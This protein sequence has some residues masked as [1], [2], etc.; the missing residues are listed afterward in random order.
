MADKKALYFDAG[1]SEV[2][3]C[4]LD[5]SRE[6]FAAS[7]RTH[8]PGRPELC[9]LGALPCV[10]SVA[11]GRL[12]ELA[13]F[14]GWIGG[15]GVDCSLHFTGFDVEFGVERDHFIADQSK[16]LAALFGSRTGV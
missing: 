16:H 5:G 10:D 14:G 7:D 2:W 8:G 1:A 9:H 4:Q 12:S 6:V 11:P 15:P 3:L 13:V